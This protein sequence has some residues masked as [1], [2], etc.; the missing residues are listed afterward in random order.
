MHR[1]RTLAMA[2]VLL[3][4]SAALI[5]AAPPFKQQLKQPLKQQLKR[6]ARHVIRRTAVALRAAQKAA[7]Q[8]HRYAYLG[9]A[10]A[11]QRYSRRLYARGF[12]LEAIH[13][14]LHARTL[15]VQVIKANRQALV[16]EA[17]LD[18]LERRYSG[19]SP[20]GADLELQLPPGEIEDD[21]LSVEIEI[22][23]DLN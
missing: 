23:L 6:D 17:Y 5:Q 3:I 20:R 16:S 9:R 18:W 21:K 14:S 12:Y 8:G 11:H 1:N 15:A 7:R 13:H 19:R 22:E 10:I 2:A 4:F